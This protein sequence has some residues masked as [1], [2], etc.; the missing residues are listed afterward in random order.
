MFM[1]AVWVVFLIV[2]VPIVICGPM[3]IL[4]SLLLR[5]SQDADVRRGRTII[6][7]YRSPRSGTLPN[8]SDTA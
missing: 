7:P 5:G 8:D 1:V 4:V 2:A 6:H 3:M